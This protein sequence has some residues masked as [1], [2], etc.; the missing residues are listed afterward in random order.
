MV[1]LRHFAPSDAP[2]LREAQGGGC[3]LEETEELIRAWN[4]QEFQG[5]YFE[6]FAVLCGGRIVGE[7]SLY[8]HSPSVLELGPEIFPAFRRQGFG[9]AALS[10]ALDEAKKRG[11]KIA[12]QQ[13]RR[14]NLASIA[15][16]NSLGFE[17]DGYVY[18]NQKG[19]KVLLF[20]KPLF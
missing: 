13:V 1:T 11:F 9:R 6:M 2:A 14:D 3:G 4:T 7:I 20:L 16:H 5:R 19:R 12:A 10:L 18:R 15:L 17:T 8:S